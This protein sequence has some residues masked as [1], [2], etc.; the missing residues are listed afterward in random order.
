MGMN[1]KL[2]PAARTSERKRLLLFTAAVLLQF[3]PAFAQTTSGVAGSTDAGGAPQDAAASSASTDIVVTANK[4]EERLRDVPASIAVL[5][6]EELDSSTAVSVNDVLRTVPG[7][8]TTTAAQSGMT[9]LSIRGVTGAGA[10]FAGSS[11]IA[12]YLDGLPFSFVKNSVVPDAGAFDLD[13]VEV[14]RGPQGTLYGASALNGVV[15]VLTNDADLND[16]SGKARGLLSGTEHGGTNYRGD[17]MLNMPII[18][19]K[20]AVRGA[21]SY[22]KLGGYIDKPNDANANSGEIQT[23]RF[24]IGAAP[25]ERLTLGAS[26]WLSRSDSGMPSFGTEALTNPNLRPEPVSNDYDAYGFKIG[27]DLDTVTL[28]SNTS[29]FKYRSFSNFALATAASGLFSQTRLT[30]ETFNQELNLASTGSGPWRWTAGAM[31]RASNEGQSQVVPGLF[32]SPLAAD[33]RSRSYAIFGELTRRFL[34]S[35]LELTGG[36]RYFHDKQR[37]TEVSNFAG[38]PPVGVFGNDTFEDVSPRV[39]LNWHPERDVTIY[40]SY[41]QGFRSGGTPSKTIRVLL[42]DFPAIKP[43]RLTNYEVG[44]KGSL[45]DGVLEYDLAAYYIKWKDI[46]QSLTADYNGVR[47][48]SIVNSES[49]SGF[50]G[51]L[52]LAVRPARG[53]TVQGSAAL[54]DLQFDADVLNAGVVLF[55]EGARLNQSPRFTANGSIDYTAPL[56]GDYT[57]QFSMSLNHVSSLQIRDLTGTTVIV[58]KGQSVTTGSASVGVTSPQGWSATLFVDNFTNQN[59]APTVNFLGFSYLDQRIQPRTIGVQLEHRF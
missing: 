12:Y 23:Y 10:L 40:A 25:T 33:Y 38:T 13:R 50:G 11:P 14:L 58:N 26:V 43:D 27:Y 29:Y 19:G 15:R 1:R 37:T 46:Q 59:H 16:F 49:A 8:A 48:A 6:G 34:D 30:T 55:P 18:E 4:R 3:N 22:Q 32:T 17:A 31:Y 36:L 24:K 53:L 57:G 20:L 28:S 21:V 45:F 44:S 52:G 41:S 54:N 35:Q 2:A 47:I 5:T 51:E 7:V 42:P 56:G 39:I 9:Q